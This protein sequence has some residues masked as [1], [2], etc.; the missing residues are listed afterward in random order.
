MGTQED[1][2]RPTVALGD[3]LAVLELT[4]TRLDPT[5]PI[6]ASWDGV[7]D[8]IREAL[9]AQMPRPPAPGE[10]TGQAESTRPS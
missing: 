1:P 5:T 7:I 8:Q 3:V 2:P 10:V 6:P 9:A 4:R